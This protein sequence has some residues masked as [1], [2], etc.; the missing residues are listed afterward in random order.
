MR[1]ALDI[2]RH[3]LAQEREA[4]RRPRPNAEERGFLPAVLEVTE[5]PP[6]PTARV[7]T[8]VLVGFFV[9]ALGWAWIGRVNEVAVAE[10][11]TVASGR[12]KVVQPPEGGIVTAIHVRDGQAVREGDPLIEL[13]NT[14]TG[15]ERERLRTEWAAARLAVARLNA[16]VAAMEAPGT[17][18][19][20][21]TFAP[22]DEAGASAIAT[23][24]ALLLTEIAEQRFRQL[25]F[26][27]EIARRQA[28]RSTTEATIRRL[29]E[30]IPLVQ[31]RAQA[32]GDL[33]RE[34]HGSR[35]IFLEAQQQLVEAQH[36]RIIQTARLAEID[37]AAAALRAQARTQAAEFTRSR[38]A[39]LAEAERAAAALAQELVK[40]EQRR[41]QQRLTAP[42]DGVVQQLAIHTVGGVVQPAQQLLVVVPREDRLEVEAMVLNRDIG[43][44]EPGQRVE[45]KLETF[46]FT[47]FGLVQGEVVSVS[48]DA[49]PD[50][51]RGL[52]YAAR[53]RLAQES[54][55]IN[56]RD[57]ALVPGM[58]ATAEI[59]TG[60]RRVL[61]Y[62]LSP[63]ARYG[64]EALRER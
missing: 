29:A 5:T 23:A 18:D 31:A 25:G 20:L 27:E 47:R 36:E 28:E 49:I 35:L 4:R 11:R 14:I 39:E 60:R 40:A 50:E 45:V 30:V 43:F 32:R 3:S 44:V 22:P 17:P 19:P 53:I 56:G 57:T 54:I 63:L 48:G 51:R 21:G 62:L 9:A 7:L 10:G 59:Q 16:L 2:L 12:S 33:A 61:D 55:A 58:V 1:R 46:T 15:A 52:V 26:I 24:R 41:S 8:W 37:T 34:G 64:H 42:I 6:S 13:D 38:K